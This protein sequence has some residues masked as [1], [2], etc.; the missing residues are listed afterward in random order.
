MYIIVHFAHPPG[1]GFS[2]RYIRRSEFHAKWT[3]RSTVHHK[4]LQLH[5]TLSNQFSMLLSLLKFESLSL[6]RVFLLFFRILSHMSRTIGARVCFCKNTCAH[7]HYTS[8]DAKS[9]VSFS[10]M[11]ENVNFFM[12]VCSL[13]KLVMS[14][15]SRSEGRS[16]RIKDEVR[17][18]TS[19]SRL[20]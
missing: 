15:C 14:I 8:D 6:M 3:L 17:S 20:I 7:I 10:Y 2:R 9:D 11:L 12:S 16:Y 5:N 4:C 13:M 1:E 18:D 19:D